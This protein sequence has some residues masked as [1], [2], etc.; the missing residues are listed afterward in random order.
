MQIEQDAR[1]ECNAGYGVL[2]LVLC[3]LFFK[4]F[5]GPGFGWSWL[6][7]KRGRLLDGGDDNYN[8]V[9]GIRVS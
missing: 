1:K 3:Y 2:R 9:F 6:A 7:T 8:K 5:F 4:S